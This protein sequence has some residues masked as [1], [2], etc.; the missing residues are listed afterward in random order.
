MIIN[1]EDINFFIKNVCL[2]NSSLV[3]IVL[4][5]LDGILYLNFVVIF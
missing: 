1:L 2:I 4:R 5:V 3:I